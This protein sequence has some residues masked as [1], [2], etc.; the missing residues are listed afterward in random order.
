[1]LQEGTVPIFEPGLEGLIKKNV[2]AKRL[3]FETNVKHIKVFNIQTHQQIQKSSI[4]ASWIL[5]KTVAKS[6]SQKN[7]PKSVFL[8]KDAKKVSK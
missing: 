4:L 8:Q 3:S 2:L 7:I 6:G 5:Q 1:M